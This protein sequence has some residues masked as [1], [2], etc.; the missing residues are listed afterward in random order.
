MKKIHLAA[1]VAMLC[2]SPAPLAAHQQD[3]AINDV[4]ATL[5]SARA[6]NDLAGMTRHFGAEGLLVDARPGPVISGSELG[7]RMKPILQRILSEKGRID[8]AYRIE[9]RSVIG[10]ILIDAGFMR[11][12]I[13]RP[14]AE[15]M[16]RYA[17]FLVTMQQ[18]RDGKW[19]IIGDASMPAQQ[20]AFDGVARTA[21]LQFD[22]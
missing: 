8:T 14:G 21:G 13:A 2:A 4:Y 12:T 20:A 22:G 1:A 7:E 18:G 11:Q 6:A 19:R 15:P 9:R 17:R 10:D 3:N 16:I 5:A